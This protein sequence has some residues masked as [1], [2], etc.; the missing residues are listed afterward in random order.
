MERKKNYTKVK[1]RSKFAGSPLAQ[2][3]AP[4]KGFLGL[5]SQPL[6][7]LRDFLRSSAHPLAPLNIYWRKS[8]PW[9]VQGMNPRHSECHIREL[10]GH[11]ETRRYLAKMNDCRS[12]SFNSRASV[13]ASENA[14]YFQNIWN[15]AKEEI[16]SSAKKKV[17]AVLAAF[18]PCGFV[19]RSHVSITEAP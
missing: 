10:T 18:Q 11:Y 8:E 4:L 14:P 5:N 19:L 2:P 9:P 1:V 15:M 16:M 17:V 7:Q 13:S 3:L 6:A 12:S